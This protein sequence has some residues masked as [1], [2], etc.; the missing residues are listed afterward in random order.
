MIFLVDICFNTRSENGTAL[1]LKGSQ[2][3]CRNK[4]HLLYLIVGNKNAVLV[5]VL[6]MKPTLMNIRETAG[7][8]V[9]KQPAIFDLFIL[10]YTPRASNMRYKQLL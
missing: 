6:G 2:R 1:V 10:L 3:L 4:L 8:F 9:L 7:D 5:I